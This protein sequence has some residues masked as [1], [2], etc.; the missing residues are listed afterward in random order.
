M[1][2]S[3]PMSVETTPMEYANA[4]VKK[5]DRNPNNIATTNRTLLEM[6]RWYFEPRTNSLYEDWIKNPK[7]MLDVHVASKAGMQA[8]KEKT[9][10]ETK[11]CSRHNSPLAKRNAGVVSDS[12]K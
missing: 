3:L 12:P 5:H 7:T 6:G 4:K 10:T 1:L 11:Y 2:F 8:K 9:P